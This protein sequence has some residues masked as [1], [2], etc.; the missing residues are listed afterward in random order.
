MNDSG[1]KHSTG[2]ESGRW[3]SLLSACFT[4]SVTC[5]VCVCA[6][7]VHPD[8]HAD[9]VH[10]PERHRVSGDALHPKGL[11][12]HLPPGAERAEAE[13]QLQSRGAG[14]HRVH[15]PVPEVQRQAERRVQD[16]A[17][18]V[19]VT[20]HGERPTENVLVLVV[21]SKRTDLQRSEVDVFLFLS[22]TDV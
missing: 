10:E 18:P 17:G 12:H 13:T 3:T 14:G 9:R 4:V 20:P 22:L 2:D 8:H 5:C 15:A 6:A 7:D 11:R 1:A 16:R 21:P 19:A